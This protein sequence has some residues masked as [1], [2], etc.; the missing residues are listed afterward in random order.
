[1]GEPELVQLKVMI[2]EALRRR[3]KVLAAEL[4]KP[5][6]ELVTQAITVLVQRKGAL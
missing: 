3:L 5:M 2:P 6:N 4:G 1:M